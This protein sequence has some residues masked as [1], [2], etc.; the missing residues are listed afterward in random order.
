[1]PHSEEG[2]ENGAI[3]SDPHDERVE[4]A[5]ELARD[6]LRPQPDRY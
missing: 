1:M 4:R 5:G 6:R 2:G 3:L